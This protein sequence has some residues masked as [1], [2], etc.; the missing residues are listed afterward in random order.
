M[1]PVKKFEIDAEPPAM[2][3]ERPKASTWQSEAYLK[4]VRSLPCIITGRKASDTDPVV[5]H[6]LIGHGEGKMGGKA[7]DLF[8]MPML[9]SEHQRFHHDPKAWEQ[10]YGSQLQHV[11]ATIKKALDMGAVV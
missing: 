6:H 8:T 10:Q 11:K 4:F 3:M 9:A 5:A 2:F 7:H 1:K